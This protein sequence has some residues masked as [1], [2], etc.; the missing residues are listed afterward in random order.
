MDVEIEVNVGSGS[1]PT[2]GFGI[3]EVERLW[4]ASREV[5][6]LILQLKQVSWGAILIVKYWIL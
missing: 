4:S 5:V 2:V 6:I 1:C 3:S